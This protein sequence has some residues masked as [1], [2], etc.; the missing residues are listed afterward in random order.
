MYDFCRRDTF[1]FK[2]LQLDTNQAL[3]PQLSIPFPTRALIGQSGGA[4]V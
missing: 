3:L 2:V 1:V 4:R